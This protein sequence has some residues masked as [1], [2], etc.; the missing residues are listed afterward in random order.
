MIFNK[1]I[2]NNVLNITM[3]GICNF[4]TDKFSNNKN[5]GKL[6]KPCHV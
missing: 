4:V 3:T 1:F 6:Y 5:S 2:Y